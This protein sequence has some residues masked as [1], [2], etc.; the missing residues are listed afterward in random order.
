MFAFTYICAVVFEC[1]CEQAAHH[2][3]LT[4]SST[5][6]VYPINV[7]INGVGFHTWL[8]CAHLSTSA[9]QQQRDNNNQGSPQGKSAG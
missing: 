8:M 6:G 1:L 7:A 3:K 4:L 5:V 2:G 9:V